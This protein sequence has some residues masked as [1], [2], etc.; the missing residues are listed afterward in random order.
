MFI[1]GP[2]RFLLPTWMLTTWGCE[3]RGLCL[4]NLTGNLIVSLSATDGGVMRTGLRP[5]RA[6]KETKD[7]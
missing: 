4:V 7:V 1:R 5:R 2:I 3:A 6:A